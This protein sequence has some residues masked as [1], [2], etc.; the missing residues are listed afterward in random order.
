[1][2]ATLDPIPP[3]V[4]RLLEGRVLR[5]CNVHHRDTVY[6]QAVVLGAWAGVPLDE[7]GEP[8]G[9]RFAAR[10]DGARPDD[11]STLRAGREAT[12][13]DAL[14]AA[15]LVL[16]RWAARMAGRFDGPEF[17]RVV[18]GDGDVV[19]LVWSTTSK[20]LSNNVASTALAGVLE[21]LPGVGTAPEPGYESRRAHLGKRARRRGWSPTTAVLALGAR[22][23]GLPFESLAGNYLRLGEGVNQQMVSESVFDS[24]ASV[25]RPAPTPVPPPG[26]SVYRVLVVRGEPVAGV[27]HTAGAGSNDAEIEDVTGDLPG[28]VLERAAREVAELPIPLGVVDFVGPRDRPG[29]VPPTPVAVRAHPDLA[30]FVTAGMPHRADVAR[31][32]LDLV[33]PAESTGRIPTVL[34][35]GER[36][37]KVVTSD[38]D[39]LL[40][41]AE[42]AVGLSMRDRMLVHGR[43][44]ERT[45]LTSDPGPE[46]LLRDPR[47]G[48]LVMGTSPRRV[49]QR[50]L[51]I[52]RA[53]V[54][55]VLGPTRDSDPAVR[56]AALEVA[57]AATEGPIVIGA[58]DPRAD[59]VRDCFE[60]TRV[61]LVARGFDRRAARD[62]LA[63]DGAVV[64]PVLRGESEQIEM[65]RGENTVARVAAT[66]LR[67]GSVERG[68]VRAV[69]TAA[70]HIAR[71]IEVDVVE[72]SK[73]FPRRPRGPRPKSTTSR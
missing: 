25:A 16:E 15:V 18:P 5:G 20:A 31:A 50:G 30:S 51:R 59:F 23:R 39:R 26:E 9:R 38:L 40:R 14:L 62:H 41:T 29:S 70:L 48:L 71:D 64:A 2:N 10:F 37:A 47:V 22:L 56:H 61:I 54:T 57:L 35:L 13:A 60:T 68:R 69:F 3:V 42:P 67:R 1:M 49:V 27:R 66:A 28:S 43:P 4:P 12:V 46:F 11:A 72:R 17:A 45:A 7:L 33:F 8:F 24:F 6:V 53:T 63:G 58:D 65:R 34:V 19:E 73:P 21:L 36:G 44:L 32:V 55:A 52:D